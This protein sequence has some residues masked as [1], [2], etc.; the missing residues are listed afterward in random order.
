[1]EKLRKQTIE[2]EE[3][4]R[5]M[6]QEQEQFVI[7]FQENQKRQMTIQQLNCQQNQNIELINKW[8]KEKESL[9]NALRIKA[10]QL[11]QMRMALIQRHTDTLQAIQTLQQRVLDDELI[12]WK[13]AQQLAGNGVPF[14]NNLDQIQE[15]CEVLAEVIWANRQQMKRIGDMCQ[16]LPLASAQNGQNGHTEQLQN[17]SKTNHT[18][19]V[20]FGH[21]YFH[22]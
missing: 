3:E 19:V 13:R 12:H 5:R 8:Q 20:Q 22:N 17:L 1:M 21:K 9:D 14:E 4:L 16:Q 18:I 6:Q 10:A 2:T 11:F 7:Q 15:W